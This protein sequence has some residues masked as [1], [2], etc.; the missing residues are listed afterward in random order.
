MQTV[1]ERTCEEYGVPYQAAGSLPTAYFSMLS[2][3][4]FLGNE[5]KSK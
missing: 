1:V 4:E 2:H 5:P 3:L